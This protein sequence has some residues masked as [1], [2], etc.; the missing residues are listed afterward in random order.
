LNIQGLIRCDVGTANND[1]YSN[2]A[3]PGQTNPDGS[4]VLLR[5]ADSKNVQP[6][7]FGMS[8]PDWINWVQTSHDFDVG[9]TRDRPPPR[10]RRRSRRSGITTGAWTSTSAL[11]MAERPTTRR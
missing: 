1:D 6:V 5:L 10:P 4:P 2:T 11:G 8:D 7:T 3:L 9:G